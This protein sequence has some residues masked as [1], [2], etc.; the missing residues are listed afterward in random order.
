MFEAGLLALRL[1][2]KK[3]GVKTHVRKFVPAWLRPPLRRDC[4]LLSY[5]VQPWKG[6]IPRS[7]PA[8]SIEKRCR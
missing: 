7:T 4:G 8:E 6:V 5:A 2:Y 3:E 1:A